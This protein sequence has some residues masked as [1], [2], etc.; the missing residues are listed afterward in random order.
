MRRHRN[1]R[2]NKQGKI[3]IIAI[4]CLLFIMTVGYSAFSTNLNI[5]AKGNILDNSVDITDNIVNEGDGLYLDSY[6]EG[7][8]V[9][10]G[11][12]PNNYIDIGDRDS[13]GNTVLWRIIS[14]EADGAY[15]IVRNDLLSSRVFDSAGVRDKNSNGAGGTYCAYGNYGCS[16]WAI[17]DN[18]SNGTNS[19]TVLKDA[20]L[21]TYLNIDYYN[22]LNQTVKNNIVSYNFRV[23]AASYINDDLNQ[24]IIDEKSAIWNGNVGLINLSDYLRSNTNKELCSTYSLNNSNYK[25]CKDTNWLVSDQ[26]YWTINSR[27]NY[28][29]DVVYCVFESGTIANINAIYNYYVRPVIYLKSSKKITGEGTES[30]PFRIKK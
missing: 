25:I 15:K 17:S 5:T 27:G 9:Y 3:I 24:Q 28:P 22:S 20:E 6:E 1:R 18:F 8:Y 21:N 26:S 19:G 29:A 7:R 16:A 23:G 12:N 30:N 13:N 4:S 14:K 10:K 11:T 2:K